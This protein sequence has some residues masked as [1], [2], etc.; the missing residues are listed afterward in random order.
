MTHKSDESILTCYDIKMM[1]LKTQ[2]YNTLSHTNIFRIL[3]LEY[4]PTTFYKHCLLLLYFIKYWFLQNYLLITFK[5]PLHTLQALMPAF[6]DYS[7]PSSY[8][9]FKVQ[10]RTCLY[11]YTLFFIIS[12]SILSHTVRFLWGDLW[13]RTTLRLWKKYIYYKNLAPSLGSWT[14]TWLSLFKII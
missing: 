12:E 4:I 6:C 11:H 3:C 7:V 2:F 5:E 9:F 8:L 14:T 1:M 13:W 10:F